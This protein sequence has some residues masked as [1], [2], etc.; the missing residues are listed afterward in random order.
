MSLILIGTNHKYSSIDFRE[1]IFISR[2][3][4]DELYLKFNNLGN[5]KG[6]VFLSTCNRIELYADVEDEQV[7]RNQIFIALESE[8]KVK[9]EKYKNNFYIYQ[10]KE[11]FKH[12]SFVAAGLDSLILGETQILGQ[13]KSFFAEAKKKKRV[14]F[15]LEYL[16]NFAIS[17]ASYI[18]RKTN[19]SKGKVSVGSI[20]VNFAEEKLGSLNNKNILIV[21]VGKVTSLILKY[22]TKKKNKII[23]VANRT[24]EKAKKLSEEI[25]ATAVRFDDLEKYIKK[26]DLLISA[27]AS[28]HLIFKK[29]SLMNLG[30]KHLLILDLAMP[31]DVSPQAASLRNISLFTI[32]DLK[33]LAEENARKKNKEIEKAEKIIA[34]GMDSIWKKFIKL[35]AEPASLLLSK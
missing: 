2:K 1:N 6:A 13:V 29:E 31:R 10:G 9:L 27:T 25:K 5:F 35:A 20:A 18:Q 30:K 3:V 8:L 21:G 17:T 28:P 32:E 7:A 12:L 11:V 24:Y 23:F 4:R 15:S 22:L 33:L 16:F 19:I 14:N 34:E 26:A